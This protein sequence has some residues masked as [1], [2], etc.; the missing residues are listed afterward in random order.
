[1]MISSSKDNLK[2]VV[3][4]SNPL[5]SL[6]INDR[7]NDSRR[8]QIKS[9][10]LIKHHRG[11]HIPIN[12]SPKK[13]ILVNHIGEKYGKMNMRTN[14]DLLHK[15][16]KS[17]ELLTD[18]IQHIKEV[19]AQSYV[20]PAKE[21]DNMY[22]LKEVVEKLNSLEKKVAVIEER[23]KK[24]EDIPTKSE[25][26]NIVIEAIE[27]KKIPNKSEVELQITKSKNTQIVWTVGTIIAV[28]SIFHFFF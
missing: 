26:K 14:D 11:G 12:I 20:A 23:T 27:S 1:M 16:Y 22:E 9:K 7:D 17:T 21:D 13:S 18:E 15:I 5:K 28:L 3:D 10:L 25:I 24:L 4:N 19:I 6:R 2:L 8:F